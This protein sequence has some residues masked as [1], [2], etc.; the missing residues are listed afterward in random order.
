MDEITLN[1]KCGLSF[2]KNLILICINTLEISK[3]VT[4]NMK[5]SFYTYDTL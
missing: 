2:K 3:N 4:A 1:R 5:P